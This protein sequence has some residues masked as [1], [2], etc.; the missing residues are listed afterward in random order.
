MSPMGILQDAPSDPRWYEENMNDFS[1]S[2]FLG[3]L[4]ATC[5]ANGKSSRS[6]NRA[7]SFPIEDR[8]LHRVY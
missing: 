4:D 6:P 2:S 1:L 8:I 5:E 3:H 7:V